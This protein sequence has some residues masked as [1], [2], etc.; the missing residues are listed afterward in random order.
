MCI[1]C[2]MVVIS[3]HSMAPRNNS[4]LFFWL[5]R[6]TYTPPPSTGNCTVVP[7][8]RGFL[9]IT[10]PTLA[11]ALPPAFARQGETLAQQFSEVLGLQVKSYLRLRLLF[12]WISVYVF[13]VGVINAIFNNAPGSIISMLIVFFLWA[14]LIKLVMNK[15][16]ELLQDYEPW[17][18]YRLSLLSQD[19]SAAGIQLKVGQ[20]VYWLEVVTATNNTT[21]ELSAL[22][23]S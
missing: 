1:Y 4:C 22:P 6:T 7:A 20:A 17:A 8:C 9:R 14:I 2:C 21:L 18:Q 5:P 12:C 19:I 23:K 11:S 3:L 15:Y 10:F 16:G 13:I